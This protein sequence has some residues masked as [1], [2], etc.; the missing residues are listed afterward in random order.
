MHAIAHVMEM[1]GRQDEGIEFMD[2]PME[3]WKVHFIL[4]SPSKCFVV[5]GTA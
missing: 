5:V 2:Q 3:A 1:E 4:N